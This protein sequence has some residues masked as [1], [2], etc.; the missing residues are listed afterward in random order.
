M[1]QYSFG[2]TLNLDKLKLNQE[3]DS[4]HE[5]SL[6]PSRNDLVFR[7]EVKTTQSMTKKE[8]QAFL[9]AMNYCLAVFR[10]EFYKNLDR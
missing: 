1:P 3:K 9:K 6:L 7:C 4:D 2:T 5:L 10:T 8:E